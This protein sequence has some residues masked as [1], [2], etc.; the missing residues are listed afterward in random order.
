MVVV[1][2]EGGFGN[3]LR[4]AAELRRLRERAGLSGRRLAEYVGISQS[5]V[6]RIEA[7]TALPTRPELTAW[8]EATDAPDETAAMLHVLADSVYTDVRPWSTVL[9]GHG[10][11]QND[12]QRLE[13]RARVK[14]VYEPSIVPG[15]LQVAGYARRLFE[16]FE[17]GYAPQDVAQAVASRVERQA[18]LYD[19]AQRFEFVVT[20]AALRLRLAPVHVLLAQL[21][22]IGSVAS[23]GNVSLGLI[24]LSTP[25][26]TYVPHGFVIFDELTEPSD[27]AT[28]IMVET[29]HANLTI[30]DPADVAVYRRQWARLR[31][32][33]TYGDAARDLLAEIA[34]ALR[35]LPTEPVS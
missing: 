15:L 30:T 14:L 29:V 32:Q 31:K 23:L 11:L 26:T 1:S 16:V 25:V 21:D 3:R 6:S 17:H 18:A 35:D 12:I 34:T 2:R 13:Q 5:K 19:P 7:S 24:P 9:L 8:A 20:E 27:P 22:R 4:L 10:D 28:L 33:A